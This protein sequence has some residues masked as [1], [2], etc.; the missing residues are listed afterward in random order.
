MNHEP[1]IILDYP[2]T[3]ETA[4]TLN[5]HTLDSKFFKP[6]FAKMYAYTQGFK[7][8]RANRL[9]LTVWVENDSVCCFC[10][11]EWA[12]CQCFYSEGHMAPCGA[13]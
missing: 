5:M 10:C 13:R 11:S 1:R 3:T 9:I 7:L 6:I 4:H 2:H 12:E 8:Y